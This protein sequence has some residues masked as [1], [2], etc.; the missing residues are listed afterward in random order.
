VKWLKRVLLAVVGVVLLGVGGVAVR[1]GVLAPAARPAPDVK[2]PSTPEA[3]ERGRY[4]ANGIAMCV[5]CHSPS[6]GDE[7]GQPIIPGHEFEGRE[8]T[9]M[10]GFPG[11]VRTA[12]LTS[13]VETG[14]GGFTDGELLRAMREGIGKDGRP[15]FPMMPYEHLREA[16]SD[17]DALAIIAYLRTLPPVKHAAG[18]TTLQFPLNVLVRLAPK[19][20]EHA[21]PPL[22]ADPLERG[23]RLMLIGNCTSCHTTHDAHHEDIAGHY[24][25]GGDPFPAP[26]GV[27]VYAPNITSDAATGIGTYSDE[28]LR[29]AITQGVGKNGRPLY[30]MPWTVFATLSEEDLSALIVALRATPAVTNAVPMNMPTT[31][32][33]SA[34]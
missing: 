33:A 9:E 20:V 2:A 29:R 4:L 8:L 18:K 6:H 7:P 19:P 22:P 15:L 34:R 10:V 5:S 23:R 30:F 28:D 14:I 16:L 17:D 24:L 13:D 26:G 3:I 1:V 12:N 32:R 31:P 25:A 27:T 21:A 11:Q